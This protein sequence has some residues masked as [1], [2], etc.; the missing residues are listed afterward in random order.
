MTHFDDYA[1]RGT[2]AAALAMRMTAMTLLGG[3]SSMGGSDTPP[4][5]SVDT[6]SMAEMRMN[7]AGGP[8]KAAIPAGLASPVATP[9]ALAPGAVTDAGANTPLGK[10]WAFTQ[11]NGFDGTLPPAPTNAT[12]LMARQNGRMTGT[13]SC[14]RMSAAFEI[15][16]VAA[17]L[18]FSNIVNGQ[19]M[20]G[21][22]NADVEDAVVNALMVTDSFLLDGKT[23]TLKSKG[24]QVAQL[25]TQ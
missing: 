4:P 12:L 6:M 19:A 23:L 11:V 16:M 2:T 22:P 17:T 13:T 3:C 24:N 21:E 20:C 1:R 18:R 8:S 14:N 25:T 15:D 7:E 10:L 9:T 5:A